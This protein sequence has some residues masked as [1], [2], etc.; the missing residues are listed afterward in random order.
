MTPSK[1]IALALA[2]AGA[3][4]APAF[5]DTNVA[6]G[7]TV[8]FSGTGFFGWSS[9]WGSG[10][11]AP[12]ASVTDGVFVPTGQQW[13]TGTIYWNGTWGGDTSNFVQI[14]LSAPAIVK[15]IIL[16]ADNN[17]MYGIQYRD[18]GGNWHG[19]A[20]ADVYGGWGMWTRPD[21]SVSPVVASAFRIASVAGDSY[22]SVSEFQAIGAP[23]PEPETYAMMLAGLGLLGFM[24]RRKK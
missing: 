22:Y 9:A 24:A 13:N 1:K 19:L 23:V 10:S 7:G 14:D 12:L 18:I 17:D 6:L 2:L 4:S 3:L 11:A 8:T 16:Q 20:T 21:I 5:A 15:S